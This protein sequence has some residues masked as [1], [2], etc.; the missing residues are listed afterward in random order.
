MSYVNKYYPE[1]VNTD[2]NGFMSVSYEK[3]SIVAL[4]AID[5]LNERIKE[6]EN[7]REKE[8]STT[9]QKKKKKKANKTNQ[10]QS[11]ANTAVNGAFQLIA[12]SLLAKEHRS[13]V[14]EKPGKAPG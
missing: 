1:I 10:K 13:S 14:Y 2:E 4:A 3:L 7:I 6:L 5:K 9:K 12:V 11:N 8:Q